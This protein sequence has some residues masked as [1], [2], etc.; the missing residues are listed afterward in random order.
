M[1]FG[2]WGRGREGGGGACLEGKTLLVPSSKTI[3]N[4][5]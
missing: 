3:P 1:Y 2:D 5:F 4:L